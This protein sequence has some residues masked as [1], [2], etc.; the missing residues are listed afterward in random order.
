VPVVS[1]VSSERI[2][3]MIGASVPIA[4]GGMI[5]SCV[6]LEEGDDI[7]GDDIEGDDIEGDDIEGDDIEG[8]NIEGDDIEGD[9]IEGDVEGEDV[10]DEDNKNNGRAGGRNVPARRALRGT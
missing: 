9:D 4:I 1:A 7:E 3:T 6:V 5:G 8:D 2:A 10:E